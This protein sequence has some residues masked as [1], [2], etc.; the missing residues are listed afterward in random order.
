MKITK[1]LALFAVLALVL[2]ACGDSESTDTTTGDGGA[3]DTTEADGGTTDTEA[4]RV[5]TRL[6]AIVERA[7]AVDAD[8][9]RFPRTWLFHRRWG[10]PADA[11]MPSGDAIEF[12]T[13]AGRTTAWVPAR[14]G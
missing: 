7:V 6:R 14:Q 3:A 11:R 2:A 10:K 4:K 1:W 12:V 5:R 9:T 8:K 13:I